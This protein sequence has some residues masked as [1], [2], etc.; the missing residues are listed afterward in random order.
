MIKLKAKQSSPGNYTVNT[1][2][3]T[4]GVWYSYEFKMWAVTW[5]DGDVE[6]LWNTKKEIMNMLDSMET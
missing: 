6:I 1:K 4:V 3:G 2:N 5:P